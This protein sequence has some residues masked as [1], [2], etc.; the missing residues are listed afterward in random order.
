MSYRSGVVTG[1]VATL[2]LA[3]AAGGGWWL[4]TN[5]PGATAKTDSHAIPAT[6]PKP[7]KE[8]QATGVILTPEAEARLAVRTATVERK[9]AGRVRVYGGE[10]TLPPGRAVVVSA[11]L[12][13]VLKPAGVVPAPGQAVKRGQ[14]VFHLLPLLDPVGRANLTAAKVDADGQVESALEQQRAANIA[15]DRAERFSPAGPAAS[16]R[17]TRPRPRW[18]SPPKHS[19]RRPPAATC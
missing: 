4:L 5:G 16:G 17:W 11:P 14:P 10:V 8:E 7:F 2:L 18:T 13:G 3:A 6:V 12:A 19:E 1:V 9:S 15:L